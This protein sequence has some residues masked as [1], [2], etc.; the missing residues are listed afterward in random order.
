MCTL[1]C[2]DISTENS[3]DSQIETSQVRKKEGSYEDKHKERH[4]EHVIQQHLCQH[5]YLSWVIAK[6][7]GSQEQYHSPRVHN[8]YSQECIPV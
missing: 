4:R 2:F 6:I 1:V 5:M 3:S 7:W 8:S